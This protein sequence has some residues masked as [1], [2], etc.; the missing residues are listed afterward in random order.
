MQFW[1]K[2]FVIV[3]KEFFWYKIL[4]SPTL[5]PHQSVKAHKLYK[6]Y[7]CLYEVIFFSYSI[8]YLNHSV[9]SAPISAGGLSLLPNFQKGGLDRISIFSGVAGKDRGHFYRGGGRGRWSSFY[10]KKIKFEI[11]NDK[12]SLSTKMFL[13]DHN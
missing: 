12:R 3:N 9:H 8:G 4:Q 5:Q 1:L 13:S 10:I 6:S 2:Q 11:F 7:K